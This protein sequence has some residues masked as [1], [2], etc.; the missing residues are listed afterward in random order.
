MTD[1]DQESSMIVSPPEEIQPTPTQTDDVR[2]ETAALID[3]IRKRALSEIQA[4]GDL[5]R[6]TY[7][8]AVRQAREAI[9]QTQLIEPHQIEQSVQQLQQD[10]ESNWHTVVKEVED[11]GHR[12]SEAAKAAWDKLVPPEQK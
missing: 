6:E 11:F 9:E 1:L 4:A 10:A 5:T 12:L 2:Q 7:L 3:A 8:N